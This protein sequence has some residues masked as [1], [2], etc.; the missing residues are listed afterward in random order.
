MS[1]EESRKQGLKGG[2]AATYDRLVQRKGLLPKGL[3]ELIGLQPAQEILEFGVGTGTVALGLSVLGHKVT[4]VDLS[5]DMLKEARRKARRHGVSMKF[6]EGDMVELKLKR[7]FDLLICLGNTL[8]LVPELRRARRF[9]KNCRDHIKPGGKAIFQIVNYDRILKERPMTFAVDCENDLVRIKQYRY[10]RGIIDFVVS[11]VD[12]S[13][14]PPSMT[15]AT[16]RIRPWTKDDLGA[17]L[18]KAGFGKIAAYG[19]YLKSEFSL[20]SKDLVMV[21]EK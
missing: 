16:N 11:L 1:N 13:R 14:I 4:G 7:E 8:P 15:T 21:A 3:A 20:S 10:R 17:E 5:T 6:M 19:D 12:N 2:F 9:L 18:R